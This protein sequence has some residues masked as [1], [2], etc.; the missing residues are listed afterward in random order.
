MKH[1]EF[2]ELW[3]SRLNYLLIRGRSLCGICILW[4]LLDSQLCFFPFYVASDRNPAE[5]DDTNV[6]GTS[7]TGTLSSRDEPSPKLAVLTKTRKEVMAAYQMSTLLA[8]FFAFTVTS[9]IFY[10]YVVAI[11]LKHRDL[12]Q[13]PFY[14]LNVAMGVADIGNIWTVYIF[15][16]LRQSSTRVNAIYLVFGN[17]GPLPFVC[18]HGMAFFNLT[19][20]YFLLI[21]G[22]NRLTAV[23][24][25]SLHKR[26]GT[27]QCRMKNMDL[28]E[29]N[30]QYLTYFPI[31]AAG[32]TF[33]MFGLILYKLLQNRRIQKTVT[34]F[35]KQTQNVEI[36]LTICVF[37]HVLLLIADGVTSL[38]GFFA[39]LS[40]LLQVNNVVQD[41]LSVCNPYL[42]ILFASQLRKA[43][44]W[45]ANRSPA[46]VISN[47]SF[48][49]RV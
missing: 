10:V 5:E 32:V 24:L 49:S 44:F 6:G 12:R 9:T 28:Y 43:V 18:I 19:Q 4:L 7:L 33:L 29:Y 34:L 17:Y 2:V 21:I 40:F 48:R 3:R 16:R 25:P 23:V 27:L 39:D 45:F 35:A 11:I 26:S 37:L 42:L 46:T 30:L 15:H 36:R 14:M 20:K 1:H 31:F 22:A 13:L 8:I 38:L 47:S 41:L